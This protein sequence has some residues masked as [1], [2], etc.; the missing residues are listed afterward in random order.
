MPMTEPR[1]TLPPHTR[2][3]LRSPAP[4]PRRVAHHQNDERGPLGLRFATLARSLLFGALVVAMLSFAGLVVKP[5]RRGDVVGN[6]WQSFG[7]MRKNSVDAM[8]FGTSHAF[9]GVDPTAVW[10]TKGIPGFVLG[11]PMQSPE[12]TRYYVQEA[13]RTQRPKVVALDVVGLGYPKDRFNRAFHQLNVGYMPMSMNRLRAAMFSTPPGERLG[14]TLDAWLYHNRWTE[15]SADDFDVWHKNAGFEYLKG[16]VP[17]PECHHVPTKPSPSLTREPADTPDPD[18]AYHLPALRA[19][20]RVCR[21]HGAQLLLLVT[22]TGP[23]GK[24][25]YY[26]KAAAKVLAEEYPNVRILDLSAPGAVPRLS[27]RTDFA[28]GGHLNADGAAKSSAVL[29]RYLAATYRLADH[30]GEPAYRGWDDEVRQ[31][32]A[33]VSRLKRE[34]R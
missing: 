3:S 32:D 19:I 10:R 5:S 31:H 9:T 26:A 7:A 20:A 1:R 27:Y 15:L 18:V 8:F 24:Y 29:A 17:R 23:P 21:E 14:V 25:T 13:F 6:P 12:V 28:D 4:R 16:W 2:P 11:G 33:Y 34:K 30:R 22:P